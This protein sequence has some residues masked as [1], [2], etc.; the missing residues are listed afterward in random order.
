MKQKEYK[1]ETRDF[2]STHSLL[3]YAKKGRIIFKHISRKLKMRIHTGLV[4]FSM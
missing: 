2:N 3:S 4:E 1:G